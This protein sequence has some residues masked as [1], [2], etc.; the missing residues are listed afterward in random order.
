MGDLLLRVVGDPEI[1]FLG[2]DTAG[3]RKFV[4]NNDSPGGDVLVRGEVGQCVVN[5]VTNNGELLGVCGD[6]G[7]QTKDVFGVEFAA[8]K[9]TG[10]VDTAEYVFGEDGGVDFGGLRD[11]VW[12]HECAQEGVGQVVQFLEGEGGDLRGSCYGGAGGGR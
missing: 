9:V 11:V 3:G 10:C 12:V 7:E 2:D 1:H 4:I 8:D 5:W 6:V